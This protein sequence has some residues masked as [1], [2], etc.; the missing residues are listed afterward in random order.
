KKGSDGGHNGMKS[1]IERIGENFSRL[2]IGIGPLPEHSDVT[3]FVLGNFKRA[4]E[5]ELDEIISR[6][7][8]ALEEFAISGIDK[9]MNKYN[10]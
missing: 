5:K 3:D 1:I 2:R 7:C 8:N 10:N 6:C 4:E 9:M